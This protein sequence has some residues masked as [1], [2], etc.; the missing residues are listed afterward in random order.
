[1]V[2]ILPAL[3]G[4]AGW[5]PDDPQPSVLETAVL[6][7]ELRSCNGAHYSKPRGAC[8]AQRP[9]FSE[10]WR[11]LFLKLAIYQLLERI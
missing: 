3:I 8:K 2:L 11:L 9:L 6:P 4:G 10:I 5:R 7:L 1:M